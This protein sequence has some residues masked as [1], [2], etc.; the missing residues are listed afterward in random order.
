VI[1]TEITGVG[2]IENR[3]RNEPGFHHA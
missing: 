3:C 1:R 2:I